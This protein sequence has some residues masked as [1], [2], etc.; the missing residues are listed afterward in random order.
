MKYDGFTH[1]SPR[2]TVDIDIRLRGVLSEGVDFVVSLY[3]VDKL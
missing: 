3:N 1:S 2:M